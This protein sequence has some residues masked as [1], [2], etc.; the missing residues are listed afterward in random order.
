MNFLRII[1]LFIFSMSAISHAM[2]LNEI[3][4]TDSPMRLFYGASARQ[5][6]RKTMED[7]ICIH[8]EENFFAVFDGHNG[9]DAAEYAR[10]HAYQFFCETS[11]D[12]W[13][14]ERL[15]QTARRL[16]DGMRKGEMFDEGCAWQLDENCDFRQ[17]ITGGTTAVLAVIDNQY[18]HC[19][20]VGD[21][22]AVHCSSYSLNATRDHKP[23]NER[24]RIEAAGGMVGYHT[25]KGRTIYRLACRV[26]T[27]IGAGPSVSRALGD[28]E[29]KALMPEI[30]ADPDS[31]SWPLHGK[32]AVIVLGSDGL[33]DTVSN[34]RIQEVV[35][36]FLHLPIKASSLSPDE[37]SGYEKT[38]EQGNDPSMIH[39][40]RCLRDE[41]YDAE[42][43][44]NI[45]VIAI[46]I[47]KAQE[48]LPQT[49]PVKRDDE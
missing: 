42:S 28:F 17:E 33:F 6:M 46:L 21:S 11:S 48:E 14:E 24:E 30:I 37:L 41:A 47:K 16:E 32:D 23:E 7:R 4:V 45:S 12:L 49:P 10:K 35:I 3:V 8:P 15:K 2:D 9:D 38:S 18:V 29:L 26:G 19:A 39:F 22:R 31:V 1:S 27:H 40:A 20:W 34:E 13:P 44:D 36:D 5:G 25:V 43:S